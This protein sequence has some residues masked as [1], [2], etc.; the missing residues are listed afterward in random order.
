M[1]DEEGRGRE[2]KREG[3]REGEGDRVSVFSKGLEKRPR[4]KSRSLSHRTEHFWFRGWGVR[5]AGLTFSTTQ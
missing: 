3:A 4:A 2:G 1:Q 5:R